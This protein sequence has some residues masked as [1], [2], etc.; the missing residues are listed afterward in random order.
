MNSSW[1]SQPIMNKL[2]S[3][4]IPTHNPGNFIHETIATALNQSYQPIEVIVVDDGSTNN[5]SDKLKS[6]GNR[7]QLIETEN[8]GSAS[9]RNTAVE[10]SSGHFL[11]FLDHDDLL[12]PEAIQLRVDTLN[13]N[14]DIQLVF[15]HQQYIYDENMDGTLRTRL[16]SQY[17]DKILPGEIISTLLLRR[18]H[19][20]KIGYFNTNRNLH[21]F[22]EWYGHAQDSGYKKMMLQDIIIKRRI[23]DANSS[24]TG[25]NQKLASSLKHLLDQ[26]R[27]KTKPNNN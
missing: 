4:I 12:M 7:I 15:G 10:A 27:Q 5:I 14:P 20:L 13:S 21:D 1:E 6:Y 9:A 26:R 23:H 2:V 22:I 25:S 8:R 11:A 17:G 18:E 24:R 3:I 16:E 19:F